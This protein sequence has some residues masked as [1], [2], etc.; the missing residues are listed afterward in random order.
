MTI[1]ATAALMYQAINRFDA[2]LPSYNGIAHRRMMRA[3]SDSTG[4]RAAN[5]S[6]RW[7]NCFSRAARLNGINSGT[8]TATV[9]QNTAKAMMTTSV[10]G[11][12]MPEI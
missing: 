4:R 2:P 7:S 8:A 3:S 12:T 9:M 10:P 5:A 1:G 6:A 11:G